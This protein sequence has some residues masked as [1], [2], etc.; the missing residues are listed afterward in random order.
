MTTS[1]GKTFSVNYY[2]VINFYHIF[3]LVS[4]KKQKVQNISIALILQDMQR[5]LFQCVLICWC[6]AEYEK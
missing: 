1:D 5:K 2:V 3:Y 4:T 6:Y